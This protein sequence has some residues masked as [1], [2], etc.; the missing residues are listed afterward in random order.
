VQKVK[1]AQAEKSETVQK[2][3]KA[4]AEKSGTVQKAKKAQAEKSETVQKAQQVA[5]LIVIFEVSMPTPDL[6][7]AMTGS[8]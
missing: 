1:K 4:Q 2:A 3:K 6:L 8:R 5:T 7:L